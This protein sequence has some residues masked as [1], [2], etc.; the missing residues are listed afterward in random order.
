MTAGLFQKAL[1]LHQQGEL[2]QAEALYRAILQQAPKHFDALHLLG[3]IACQRTQYEAAVRLIGEALQLDPNSAAAH[4]NQGIALSGLKRPAE[5][6]ACYDR[7]LALRPDY[8]EALNNRGTAL[9]ELG[10]D[11]EAL[12]SYE[13]AL[14]LRPDDVAAWLNHARTLHHLERYE[15]ALASYDRALTITPGDAETLNNR[16]EALRRLRRD[17]EALASYERALAIKPDFFEALNNRGIVLFALKRPAEALACYDRA[18]ALRPDHAEVMNNRGLALST[19]ARHEEAAAQFTRLLSIAPDF[20]NA[21]GNLLSARLQCCDW[22]DYERDVASIVRDVAG[23]KRAAYPLTFLSV[24]ASPSDQLACARLYSRH[25]YP[26][27]EAP[28]WQGERYRHERIRIAYLSADFRPHAVAY[29]IAELFETH[30]RA[31]FEI[32]AISFGRDDTSDMRQRLERAFDRFIEMRGKSDREVALLLKALEIDIA[33]DLTGYTKD[34]RAGILAFR[35]APVQVNYLGYPGTMGADFI[36]YILAD[37]VIIPEDQQRFYSEKIAYLPDTYQ[38]NDSKRRIAE[39]TPTRGEAGLPETGFVFCSFNNSFKIT[40]PVFDIWMRLLRQVQGSVLWLL[41]DNETALRNLRREAEQ[42]GVAKDRLVFAPRLAMEDHLA[43][44]RLA[45]LLLD[46]LPYNAHTTASDALWTGL[47]VVTCLGA[48]FAAR[49]AGSLLNAV[50]LPELVTRS[51]AEYEA[52][53]LALA[54]DKDRLTSIRAK[55]AQNRGVFPLFDAERFR[56]HIES[57]FETMWQ[58]SQ[59]GEP[60]AS[61]AVAPIAPLPPGSA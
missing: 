38:P 58:R 3:V 4:S 52:L 9:R 35:P 15:E 21:R 5:A 56:R 16:G 46:T 17:A 30:D 22:R 11:G 47:P 24:S 54:R 55:L 18:L 7:A 31:R 57:A 37:P 28:L 27:A 45:D 6:L 39:P 1:A 41:E 36:D 26:T 14:R 59:R 13:A 34:G 49:V 29:L 53:A 33:V 51:R 42:R 2:A 32:T 10:R 61:F 48:G 40:P 44:H 8:A 12:A 50:G 23:G 19:L 60:P 20:E 25:R 43:R